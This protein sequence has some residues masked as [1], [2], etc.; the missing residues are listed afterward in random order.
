MSLIDDLAAASNSKRQCTVCKALRE[1]PPKESAALL[2]AIN[3][4]DISIAR[5]V[6][7]CHNNDVVASK[8]A[9][10]EHRNKRCPKT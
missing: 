10:T 8:G 9:L 2:D 7:A 5:I 4:P 6:V 3:N 1:L